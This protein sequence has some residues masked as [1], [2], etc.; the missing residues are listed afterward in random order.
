MLAIKL[1]GYKDSMPVDSISWLQ[2]EASYTRVHY[3]DGTFTLISQPLRWFEQHLDFVRVHR[4]AIVN[5]L[6]VQEFVQKKSRAGWIR[7]T[8]GTI[9]SVS[10]GRLENTVVQLSRVVNQPLPEQ[11]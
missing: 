4:S 8:D 9:V 3:Q 10:R 5:P 6:F 1:K 11:S 7:L 2:A